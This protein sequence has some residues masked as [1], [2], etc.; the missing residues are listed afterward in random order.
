[1][2]EFISICYETQGRSHVGSNTPCQDRTYSLIDSHIGII[3]LCDGAGSARLS[4]YGS[5][6]TSRVTANLI[7]EN[8][9]KYYA[10][11]EPSV[12]AKK[13]LESINNE[14]TK[15]SEIRTNELK[16]KA[17]KEIQGLLEKKFKS[18]R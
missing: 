2:Q 3:T 8:F 4:H 15:E 6:R 1:M 12:V 18:S 13:I 10:G 7:K 17:Y 9:D 14:L 5:E 11:A 16:D